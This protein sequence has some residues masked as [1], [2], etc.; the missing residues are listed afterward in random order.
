MRKKWEK[1]GRLSL[2]SEWQH[3]T[4]Q[5]LLPLL[6]PMTL[7]FLICSLERYVP[8][9]QKGQLDARVQKELLGARGKK[10]LLGARGQKGLL[11][12]DIFLHW[13]YRGK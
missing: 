3:P 7:L 6:K 2:K 9:V 12:V 4:R 10:G 1:M 11:G 8:L 13:R 5:H